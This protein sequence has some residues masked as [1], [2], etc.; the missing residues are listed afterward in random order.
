MEAVVAALTRPIPSNDDIP[1]ITPFDPSQMALEDLDLMPSISDW[2]VVFKYVNTKRYSVFALMQ[3]MNVLKDFFTENPCLRLTVCAVAA[4]MQ[5]PPL[6]VHVCLSYYNRAQKSLKKYMHIVSFKTFQALM[7]V[8]AFTLMHGLPMAAKPYFI[9]AVDMLFQLQLDVDPN[10][11]ILLGRISEEEKEQRRL[12]SDEWDRV[13]KTAPKVRFAKRQH[14]NTPLYDQYPIRS[15][16]SPICYLAAFLDVLD[17]AVVFQ[18]H[19]PDSI[20][21]ILQN[22]TVL[23]FHM[24]LSSLKGQIPSYLILIPNSSN[25]NNDL[26]LFSSD[27]T[28]SSMHI[29]DTLLA[30]IL[31]HTTI[32]IINRPQVWLTAFLPLS[33]PYLIGDPTAITTLLS[34]LESSLTSS[35]TILFL[36][37]WLL[38][39]SK[40]GLDNDNGHLRERFWQEYVFY[41]IAMFESV[42]TAWFLVCQTQRFWW[43][44][45]TGVDAGM[46]GE[47]LCLGVEDVRMIRIQVVDVL[48]TFK[49]LE[50]KLAGRKRRAQASDDDEFFLFSSLPHAPQDSSDSLTNLASPL[51]QA[52]AAMLGDIELEEA[53]INSGSRVDWVMDSHM[54]G[55][56]GLIIGMKVVALYEED[57]YPTPDSSFEEPWVLLGP[58]GIE[59]GA[60]I[61]WHAV[62]EEKWRKFWDELRK[63]EKGYKG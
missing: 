37:S 27:Y 9:L 46:T 18:R 8:S 60:K 3:G 22:Q 15:E 17:S 11:C 47:P 38:H 35:R 48:K 57:Y 6:P 31:Y 40:M 21:T 10:D 24:Q 63:S 59:F 32:C 23:S 16:I 62:Y 42:V 2:A 45:N 61:R 4:K 44:E 56:E 29:I 12:G 53:R 25:T 14:K 34:A 43:R 54:D 1:L 30:T 51:V 20:S 36:A 28:L 55:I 7:I 52:T 58:L 49:D 19:S 50:E 13:F 33:S 5:N 26:S 41:A 39:R